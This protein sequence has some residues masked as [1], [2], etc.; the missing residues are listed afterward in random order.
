[1]DWHEVQEFA[2]SLREL[3]TFFF[4]VAANQERLSVA[5]LRGIQ[6]IGDIILDVPIAESCRT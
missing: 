4:E 6:K 3:R 2:D 1:M 5:G